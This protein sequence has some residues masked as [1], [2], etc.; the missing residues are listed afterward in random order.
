LRNADLETTMI[1][2]M[3]KPPERMSATSLIDGTAQAG[4]TP[5]ACDLEFWLQS[6]RESLSGLV[7]G[8]APGLAVPRHMLEPGPLREASLKEF[9][10]RATTE[11]MTARHLSH[12]VRL[13]PDQ[14]TMDFFATQLIDEARHADVFRTHLVEMGIPRGELEARMAEIVGAKRDTILRPLEQFALD[15]IDKGGG[16]FIGGVIFLTVIGEGALAPAAE[17]SER[18]WFLLDPAASQVAHGANLDEIRH[19]GVGAEVVRAHVERHPDERARLLELIGRGLKLWQALP[20]LPLL[21]EREALFQA[22]MVP[23]RHLLGD[24]ELVPGRRLAD[25]TVEE[26]IGLQGG[27]SD[28][29]RGRRLER[30]GLAGLCLA[31]ER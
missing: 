10:F 29:M 31:H 21:V 30:M 22:G 17:M 2:P 7:R 23:L 16:D 28:E 1:L 3:V 18:K 13:A 20:I 6:T 8:H 24:Y 11:Q 14:A 15:L 4:L 5:Q 26:R 9:A 12:L 27:W 19:L 25:T